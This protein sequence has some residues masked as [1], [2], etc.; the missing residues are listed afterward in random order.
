MSETA[1]NL[2]LQRLDARTEPTP[3]GSGGRCAIPGFTPE[4]LA[5]WEFTPAERAALE[6]ASR[7]TPE[8]LDAIA[9]AARFTPEELA[10]LEAESRIL[11]DATRTN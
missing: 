1:E 8:E 2:G 3:R 6:A 5:A 11:G 7:F 10:T 9:S 4:E